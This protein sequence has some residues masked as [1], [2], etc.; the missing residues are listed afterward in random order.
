MDGIS[1]GRKRERE[2]EREKEIEKSSPLHQLSYNT[3]SS[4][5][6]KRSPLL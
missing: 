1:Q 2:R 3:N 4:H 5:H 6:C